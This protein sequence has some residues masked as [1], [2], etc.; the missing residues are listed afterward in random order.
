ME[1]AFAEELW[2]ESPDAIL[3]VGRDGG[4]MH[5]NRA[6]EIMFGFGCFEISGQTLDVILPNNGPEEERRASDELAAHD[7]AVFEAV[8]RRKDAPSYTSASRAKPFA[9]P[10]AKCA[11]FGR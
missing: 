2:S 1:V 9:M 4:V 10:K 3:A 11:V 6:A 5:W 8:R 7:V